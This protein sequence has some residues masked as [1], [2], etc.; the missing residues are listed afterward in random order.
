MRLTDVLL[1]SARRTPIG[2]PCGQF[3]AL[4]VEQLGAAALRSAAAPV[5]AGSLPIYEGI[6]GNTVG[7]GGNIGRLSLLEAGLPVEIPGL[8][9]DR[10]C[11]SGL[12]AIRL[13]AALL[14]EVGV[15]LA[16]GAESTSTSPLLRRRSNGV[17]YLARARMSP[18]WIGDPDMAEAAEYV[19]LRYG[20]RRQEQ[21]AWACR[22]IART[23]TS[24]TTGRLAWGIAPVAGQAEDEWR[25]RLAAP[26]RLARYPGLVTGGSQ[27]TVANSAPPADGAAV[28]VLGTEQMAVRT[29]V[30]PCARLLA[31]AA[32][33]VTPQEPGMGPV[34]ALRAACA[35]AGLRPT[36][37]DRVEINEAYAAQVLACMRELDLDPE[38]VN[39]EGGAIALGHPFGATGALLVVRLIAGLAAGQVGAVTLGIGGGL[40]VALLIQRL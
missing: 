27:V 28:L 4:P 7:P 5:L 9:V 24:I 40:G 26:E 22:S 19:A 20:I 37:L 14:T 39:P 16:G 23:H 6:L 32:S 30:S 21:D 2:R 15:V 12:E 1:L 29:G 18:Q 11:G 17:P 34:P 8:T 38:R 36:A 25:E 10:Q 33:G 13:G 35:H 3:R 31:F